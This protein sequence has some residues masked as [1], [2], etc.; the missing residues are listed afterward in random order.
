MG[1]IWVPGYLRVC[2]RRAYGQKER[3]GFGLDVCQRGA[4]AA[5]PILIGDIDR[6]GLDAYARTQGLGA[7]TKGE[8]QKAKKKSRHADKQTANSKQTHKVQLPAAV[9]RDGRTIKARL[10][11]AICTAADVIRIRE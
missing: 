3:G 2:E 7:P 6:R 8:R 9:W 5:A 1:G 11:I 10:W 4:Q